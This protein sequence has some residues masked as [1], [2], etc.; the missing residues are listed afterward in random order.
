[1]SDQP[2]QKHPW[3]KYKAPP[4]TPGAPAPRSLTGGLTRKDIV[5]TLGPASAEAAKATGL[6]A[7]PT[8]T[9]VAPAPGVERKTPSVTG[10]S[11]GVG[12]EILPESL[13]GNAAKTAKG[14]G[15]ILAGLPKWEARPGA[16]TGDFTRPDRSQEDAKLVAPVPVRDKVEVRAAPVAPPVV[17]VEVEKPAVAK[18]SA[19]V[20][21][22]LADT[23]AQLDGFDT[24][25]GWPTARKK[26]IRPPGQG[27]LSWVWAGVRD[28]G[29]NYRQTGRRLGAWWRQWRSSAS[30][31]VLIAFALIYGLLAFLRAPSDEIVER[32]RSAEEIAYLQ[33]FLKTYCTSGGKVLAEKPHGGA[34]LYPRGVL[35][36]GELRDSF[37][38]ASVGEVFSVTLTSAESNPLNG[39]YGFPAIYAGGNYF[40]LERKFNFARFQCT[41]LIKKES[42]QMGVMLMARVELAK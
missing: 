36:K 39:F 40:A 12:H 35:M 33:D 15:P 10:A 1:L 17:V 18:A 9:E 32:S 26:A 31:R 8:E 22:E 20:T 25:P 19:P 16:T 11:G 21:E 2:P 34:E 42:E 6:V 30:C 24:V 38:R 37:M 29:R 4:V 7:R 27:R 14:G 23:L 28:S 41:Y 13:S 3:A 5:A